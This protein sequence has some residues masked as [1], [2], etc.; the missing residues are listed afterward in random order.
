MATPGPGPASGLDRRALASYL[1]LLARDL[2]A[3]AEE[4]TRLAST[5]PAEYREVLLSQRRT[6]L[7]ISHLCLTLLAWVSTEQDQ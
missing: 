6:V 1:L 4:L 5:A 2:R 3:D 7:M